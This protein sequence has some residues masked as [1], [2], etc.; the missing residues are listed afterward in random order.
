ML[1]YAV[2]FPLY[3]KALQS[4]EW[5]GEEEAD[6]PVK[7]GE[8]VTEGPGYLFRRTPYCGGGLGCPN[9]PSSGVQAI[10]GKLMH[11]VVAYGE[12]EVDGRGIGRGELIP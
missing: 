2:E 9:G 10:L 6:S 11:R 8:C 1:A 12:Y 3:G 7:D 5:Q 4:G